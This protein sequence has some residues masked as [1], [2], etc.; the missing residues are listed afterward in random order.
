MKNN[1]FSII[2]FILEKI[3]SYFTL[4]YLVQFIFDPNSLSN[5]IILIYITTNLIIKWIKSHWLIRESLISNLQRI[6]LV[7]IEQCCQ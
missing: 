5:N 1:I 7:P 2:C 6:C 3:Y 4:S